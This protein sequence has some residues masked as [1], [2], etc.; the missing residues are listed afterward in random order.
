MLT[1]T[2][3]ELL[4]NKWCTITITRVE[5]R[6]WMTVNSF[7]VYGEA[8]EGS[9][10][11]TLEMVIWLGGVNNTNIINSRAIFQRGFQGCVHEFKVSGHSWTGGG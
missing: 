9:I 11:L 5:R 2:G 3:P 8:P 6:T 7:S 4:M 1:L 10:G